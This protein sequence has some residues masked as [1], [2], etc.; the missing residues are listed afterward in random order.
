MT[1]FLD[2]LRRAA[3]NAPLPPLSN[4][5]HWWVI[6]SQRS[7]RDTG[8]AFR[9]FDAVVGQTQEEAISNLEKSDENLNLSMM[10][11]AL[12]NG[13]ISDISEWAPFSTLKQ[14]LAITKVETEGE[15]AA[16]DMG[17]LDMLSEHEFFIEDFEDD[18]AMS[19]GGSFFYV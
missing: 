17:L 8:K 19:V 15:I 13:E 16:I 4:G 1:S 6:E 7:N 11:A 3:K 2:H 10:N 9:I 12:A 14:Y 5:R 18:P